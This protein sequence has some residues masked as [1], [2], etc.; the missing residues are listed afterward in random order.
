VFQEFDQLTDPESPSLVTLSPK[1]HNFYLA[2][3]EFKR[4]ELQEI[5]N[6]SHD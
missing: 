6:S 4:G 3:K 1:K 2:T 5:L